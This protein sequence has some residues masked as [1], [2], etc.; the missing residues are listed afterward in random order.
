M[1]PSIL[2]VFKIWPPFLC[3][4]PIAESEGVVCTSNKYT[5]FKKFK[6]CCL[7]IMNQTLVH[8]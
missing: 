8:K 3:L 2:T 4:M 7:T 5:F 6:Y 1:I